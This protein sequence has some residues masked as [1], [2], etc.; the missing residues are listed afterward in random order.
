MEVASAIHDLLRNLHFLIVEIAW[1]ATRHHVL[2]ELA[3][4]LHVVERVDLQ[5]RQFVVEAA[6]AYLRRLRDVGLH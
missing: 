3:H 1:H 4:E 5:L 6:L 2:L